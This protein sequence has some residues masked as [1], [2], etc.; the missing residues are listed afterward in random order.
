M[1]KSVLDVTVS[2]LLCRV[3]CA[4]AWKRET[5]TVLSVVIRNSR[6]NN[7]LEIF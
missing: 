6:Y 4:S 7:I 1:E 3:L 2:Y 5:I